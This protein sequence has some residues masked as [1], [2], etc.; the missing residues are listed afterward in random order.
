MGIGSKYPR[1]RKSPYKHKV[2]TYLRQ[3][4][5]RVVKYV[6]GEG[7][8]RHLALSRKS[9][10]VLRGQFNVTIIYGD[11]SSEFV[12]VKSK[13]FLSAVNAGLLG[14]QKTQNPVSITIRR[15]G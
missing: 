6:R 9:K 8:K 15:I 14:R 7:K 2:N 13:T 3:S 11:R 12:K 4:G 1:H 10:K 5:V